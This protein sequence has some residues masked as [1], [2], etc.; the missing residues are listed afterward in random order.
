VS[1]WHSY[2]SI[3][4]LGHRYIADLL[5]GPVVVE[6]KVDGSQFSFGVFDEDGVRVLRCRSKGKELDIDA[7]EK[8]FTE[9]V[10]SVVMIADRLTP[11]WTYRGEYLKSPHHNGLA[12]DRIPIGHVI[13]FDI[14]VAEESYLDP[15]A[16]AE[17][18]AR[19]GLECVPVLARGM[20][21]DIESFRALLST[22]SVL[23]GPTI[24]GVVVKPEGYGLFGKDKK[25]LLGKFVSE[26]YK[27]VQ[28]KA[29]K[30]TNPTS[31]DVLVTIGESLATDARWR[32]AVQHLRES[33]Q[34]EDSPRDIG[35]LIREV[36]ADIKSDSEE[37]I[38]QALFSWA[39][40]HLSRMAT[41]GLADWY[42]AELL[43]RQFSEPAA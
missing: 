29:W 12:Y 22:V 13:L 23:G 41:R 34:I 15:G 7:P 27:E 4:A 38:K 25:V 14:N 21:T 9:A 42:K 30:T 39:W 5:T 16:R 2:P 11:G 1:S 31:G 26:A 20:V 35:R 40:P 37:A 3:F 10:Q 33:G 17:E 19:V 8:M 6:E 43:K 18:A 32:K 36:P 28:A 24:E